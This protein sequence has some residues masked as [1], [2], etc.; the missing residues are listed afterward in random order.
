[1]RIDEREL[2]PRA[3]ER[4]PAV[5]D[6]QLGSAGAPRDRRSPP[7]NNPFFHER[8]RADVEN[9]LATR[10]FEKTSSGVPDVLVRYRASINQRVDVS[11]V[12]RENSECDNDEE[13]CRPYVYDAD[14]L[15]IDL[16]DTRTDKVVWRG[17]TQG[18]ADGAID[19]QRL[20]EQKVD[21]AVTRILQ[22]LP[23]PQ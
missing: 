23:R 11:S 9:E 8:I 4:L 7:R 3:R 1:V 2:V 6:V 5:P 17:W 10:G 16:V 22:Q 19:N 20:M 21:K 15:L 13:A 18:R 12:D 14:T